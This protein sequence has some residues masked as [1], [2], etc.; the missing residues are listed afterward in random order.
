MRRLAALA[1]LI[2]AV[3]GAAPAAAA[4][5][6][7]HMSAAKAH[8]ALSKVKR[9]QQGVGVKTGFEMSPALQR[10]TVALPS[11]TGAARLQAKSILARPTD[12][13]ADPENP[14]KWPGPEAPS[15][16]VCTAHFCVHWTLVGP[17][18]ANSTYA[19]EMANI[20]ENEVYLCEN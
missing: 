6:R 16:P 14:H 8:A 7:A 3:G 18:A 19:T 5:P 10:L 17:D 4:P 20:L 1:A 15:S 2:A 12:S 13:Q 9:L 11:L